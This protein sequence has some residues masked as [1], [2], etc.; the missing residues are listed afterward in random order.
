M[1]KEIERIYK[2]I[3]YF[4][5]SDLGGPVVVQILA[6]SESLVALIAQLVEQLNT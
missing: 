2:A 6:T 3:T 4:Q 1:D 5:E